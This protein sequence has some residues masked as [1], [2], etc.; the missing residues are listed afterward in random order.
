MQ[1][2]GGQR[3]VMDGWPGARVLVEGQPDRVLQAAREVLV[4]E[5][6]TLAEDRPEARCLKTALQP[7]DDKANRN[8]ADSAVAG[9]PPITERAM[10]VLV[11]DRAGKTLLQVWMFPK[12]HDAYLAGV[13]Q[14]TFVEFPTQL[15]AAIK[16]YVE[17][18]PQ[19]SPTPTPAA[20]KAPSP[21]SRSQE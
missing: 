12:S 21:D 1:V 4:A 7:F 3:R 8:L 5:G 19:P 18:P 16:T 20:G 15:A 6:Y 13:R 14:P 9:L 17:Q 11:S 10:A 2:C